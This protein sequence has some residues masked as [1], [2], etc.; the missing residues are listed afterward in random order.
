LRFA[1]LL[2]ERRGAVQEGEVLPDAARA[3]LD[4]DE[5]VLEHD[6]DVDRRIGEHVRITGELRRDDSVGAHV[7]ACAERHRRDLQH[8]RAG[9]APRRPVGADRCIATARRWRRA[10]PAIV[11]PA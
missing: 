2:G 8:A 11:R 10:P 3:L 7:G 1:L 5:A 9:R 4:H 6:V